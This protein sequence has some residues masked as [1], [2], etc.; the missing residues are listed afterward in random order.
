MIAITLDVDWAPDFVIDW[1]SNK[2]IENNVKATW[3]VTH[4]SPAI[5]KL[6]RRPDLFELG[7]HPNFL[8]GSTHGSAPEEI[9]SHCMEIVPEAASMRTHDLVQS[10]QLLEC[11]M[12]NTPITTDV[13]LFLPHVENLQ[14]VNYHWKGKILRRLPYFWED[15]YEIG[16]PEP[17]FEMPALLDKVHGLKIF[18]FHPI[19]VYLNSRR[20]DSYN[21]I[22]KLSRSLSCAPRSEADA[23]IYSGTGTGSLFKDVVDYMAASGNSKWIRDL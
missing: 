6:R 22:K 16:M 19:H 10:T 20:C 11:V 1:V 8:P 17:S 12:T 2:L 4:A 15:D 14:P 23:Y 13:S 21:E 3:F 5:E 18:N 9:L 7:I